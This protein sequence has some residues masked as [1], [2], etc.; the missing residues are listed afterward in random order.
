MK[1]KLNFIM[2][3]LENLISELKKEFIQLKSLHDFPRLYVIS[4]FSDLRNEV[5][6]A[7]SS[8]ENTTNPDQIKHLDSNW[9]KITDK[10]NEFK[11]ECLD[12]LGETTPFI[13]LI[14]ID[15][16]NTIEKTLF[17]AIRLNDSNELNKVRS[18]IN[19]YIL[20]LERVI[21][22]NKS[23]IFLD[24][25]KYK[26]NFI[27]R[28][29]DQFT[30]TGKLLII[31]NEY[32]GKLNLQT[33]DTNNS[34]KKLTSQYFK[35]NLYIDLLRS[36][37]NDQQINEVK[38]EQICNLTEVDLSFNGYTSVEENLFVNLK[39]LTSINLSNN[40]LHTLDV[41]LFSELSD[42]EFI[43]LSFNKLKS[44]DKSMFKNN[45][46]LKFVCLNH[47]MLS[48]IDGELFSS[49][50]HLTDIN[51][52]NNRL[53]LV[54]KHYFKG[55]NKLISIDLSFNKLE[56][57]STESFNGLIKLETIALN[58][59]KLKTIYV[60]LFEGLTSLISVNLANNQLRF[61]NKKHF[62]NIPITW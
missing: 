4:Y 49:L 59:N 22:K 61:I 5:N 18:S 7:F 60:N 29:M 58:N 62:V 36:N 19:S 44:I 16:L 28:K 25:K 42:L 57:I 30:T 32:L 41:S 38:Y 52:A 47:N 46:K 23:M 33:N 43:D 55:L 51:L 34:S 48:T 24:R 17:K 40:C 12:S 15:N 39:H 3:N 45:K 31:S 13:S 6:Q 2:N 14:T 8:I 11:N 9:T 26:H 1:K 27:Y 37:L 50:K 56:L 54:N 21:F 35:F 10:I 53:T 20:E